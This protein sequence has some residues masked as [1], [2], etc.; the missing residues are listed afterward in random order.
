M[1]ELIGTTDHLGVFDE[2][3]AL[4]LDDFDEKKLNEYAFIVFGRLDDRDEKY[5]YGPVDNLLKTYNNY[6]FNFRN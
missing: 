5:I 4:F 6:L 1:Q 3:S 2:I